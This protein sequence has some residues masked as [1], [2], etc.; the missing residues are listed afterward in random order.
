VNLGAIPAQPDVRFQCV[1]GHATFLTSNA[2]LVQEIIS[3]GLAAPGDWER[4]WPPIASGQI[5]NSI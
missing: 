1:S 2:S 3:S 4:F 5:S